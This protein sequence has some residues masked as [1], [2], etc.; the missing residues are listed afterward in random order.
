MYRG[1]T[2]G[3]SNKTTSMGETLRTGEMSSHQWDAWTNNRAWVPQV[4]KLPDSQRLHGA[5][6]QRCHAANMDAAADAS[7]PTL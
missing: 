5:R 3:A 7:R 1:V 4:R 6:Q 2:E